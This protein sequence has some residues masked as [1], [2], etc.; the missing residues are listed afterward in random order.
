M[1]VCG[2]GEGGGGLYVCVWGVGVGAGGGVGRMNTSSRA[3][4]LVSASVVVVRE[5]LYVGGRVRVR[6]L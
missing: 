6:A 3:M 5:A 1:C 2:D 4:R